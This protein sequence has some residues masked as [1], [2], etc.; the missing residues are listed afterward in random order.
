MENNDVTP[1]EQ[2]DVVASNIFARRTELG[3][4]QGVVAEQVGIS[5]PY[6]SQIESGIRVPDVRLLARIAVVLRTTSAALCSPENFSSVP[7]DMK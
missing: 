5:R 3:F 6:L 2:C 1:D 7:V 4:R